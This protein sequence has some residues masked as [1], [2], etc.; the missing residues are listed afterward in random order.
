MQVDLSFEI[1]F[2]LTKVQLGRGVQWR[3]LAKNL[4]GDDKVGSNFPKS[5][6]YNCENGKISIR[7][8]QGKDKLKKTDLFLWVLELCRLILVFDM[9]FEITKV[10]LGRGLQWCNFI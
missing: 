9:I 4:L 1:I 3:N 7:Y 10:Q 8:H 5:I 6:E 2:E